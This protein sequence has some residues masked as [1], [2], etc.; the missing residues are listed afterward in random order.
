[1]TDRSRTV[2]VVVMV[3]SVLALVM[4]FYSSYRVR[5]YASCQS[6][7]SEALI[8]ATQATA[9]AAEQDRQSDREESAA[10]AELIRTVFT[11]QTPAERIAA[12][13]S[14]REALDDINTA[15]LTT[16]ADRQANPLPAPPSQTCG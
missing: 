2:G 14:Y 16:E 7:V 11:V 13:T 8:R 3:A 4:A 10:T 5:A 1:M 15:R 9:E 12:Y 6:A